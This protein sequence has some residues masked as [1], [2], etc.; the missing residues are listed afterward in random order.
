MAS[1]TFKTGRPTRKRRLPMRFR[2]PTPV[3]PN[4]LVDDQFPD[5]F[6]SNIDDP[7]QPP[8]SHISPHTTVTN[9][10]GIFRQYFAKPSD[11]TDVQLSERDFYD[12]RKD[13]GQHPV[14][15]G[16]SSSTTTF[17][18]EPSTR[19]PIWPF[20]NL[21][22]LLFLNW[23]HNGKT[24]KSI[25]ERTELVNSVFGNPY[26]DASEVTNTS[27]KAVE[28][29]LGW[30]NEDPSHPLYTGSAWKQRSVAISI[31]RVRESP[32][33]FHVPGLVHRSITKAVIASLQ[34]KRPP[35]SA[36]HYTPFKSFWKSPTD[37]CPANVERVYDELYSSNLWWREHKKI[38]E[39]PPETNEDGSKCTLECAI[40]GVMLWSDAAQLGNFGNAKIWPVYMFLGNQS[41]FQRN[42][43]SARECNHIAYI[44]S[45]SGIV[46]MYFPLI[47]SF[48]FCALAP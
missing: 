48:V 21:S 24:K 32:V 39:L 29:E 10:F 22:E 23:F 20:N 6:E 7:S 34:K 47:C 16:Q 45:V 9:I 41:K 1:G 28:A 26:F 14:D 4:K 33:S 5:D 15:S 11:E 2:E 37:A 46:Q 43:G 38:Q 3:G 12:T 13:A 42:K 27:L 44:P 36:L 8:P 35:A 25:G 30:A 31:P 18:D 19:S 40:A 17:D